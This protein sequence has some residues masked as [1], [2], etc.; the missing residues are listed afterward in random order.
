MRVPREAI[1]Q[2]VVSLTVTSLRV[3]NFGPVRGYR[4]SGSEQGG[5]QYAG[6]RHVP[7]CERLSWCASRAGEAA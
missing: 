1:L 4:L 5:G 2:K 6:S 3:N 7:R